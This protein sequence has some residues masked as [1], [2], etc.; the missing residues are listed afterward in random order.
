M[1][2]VAISMQVKGVRYTVPCDLRSK[3]WISALAADQVLPGSPDSGRSAI[4]QISLHPR[5]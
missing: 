3:S 1:Q 4:I 2:S 5:Q